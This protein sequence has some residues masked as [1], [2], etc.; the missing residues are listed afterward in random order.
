[1]AEVSSGLEY[2]HSRMKVSIQHSEHFVHQ[3]CK[4]VCEARDCTSDVP[5]IQPKALR[6]NRLHIE[7]LHETST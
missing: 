1:M 3:M 4:L 7:T 5:D 6:L 2:T